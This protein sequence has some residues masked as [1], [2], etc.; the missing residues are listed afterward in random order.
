MRKEW[1]LWGRATER[2]PSIMVEARKYLVVA[3]NGR[4]WL[5]PCHRTLFKV[6]FRSAEVWSG[7][8]AVTTK[9][10]FSADEMTH[11]DGP[12]VSR[13]GW[14]GAKHLVLIEVRADGRAVSPLPTKAIQSLR[15][16][17]HSAFG[18]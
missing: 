14:Q 12:Y 18:R 8:A 11:E 1:G 13:L 10:R 4:A 6:L 3:R 5:Q 17:L 7:G 9:L 2:L 16:R 15:L